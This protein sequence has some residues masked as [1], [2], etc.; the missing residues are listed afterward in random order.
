M[1]KSLTKCVKNFLTDSVF[2]LA[3]KI[4]SLEKAAET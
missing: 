1:F 3:L 2:M 4:K